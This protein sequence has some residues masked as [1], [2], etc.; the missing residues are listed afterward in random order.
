MRQHFRA[1]AIAT[2]VASLLVLTVPAFAGMISNTSWKNPSPITASTAP[3]ASSSHYSP[4][5]GPSPII[6]AQNPDFNG[7]YASQNDTASGFGNFATAFDNFTLG[8]NYNIDE[9]QWVGSYFNPPAQG[10]ITAF[11]LTFYADAGGAPG[12][13]LA[14]YSGPGSFGE[15]FVGFDNAGSPTFV[16]AGLLGSPFAATAGTQYWISLVPDLGFPPQWGWET[17]TGGDGAAYQCFFGA[18][19]AVPGDLAFAL[20]G[21]QQTSVPEPGSLMLLGT[22]ILG[23]AGVIRR[24]L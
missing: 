10:V 5:S 23:L 18:C 19:G 13:V 8:A 6:Y 15:T 14:T 1:L 24:K 12:A 7:A 9:V 2:L 21:T 11:T 20:N 16:Y 3:R 4:V 17:G 22:G